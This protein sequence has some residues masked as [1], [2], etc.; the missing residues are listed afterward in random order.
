MIGFLLASALAAQCSGSAC[1][2][3]CTSCAFQPVSGTNLP[4]LLDFVMSSATNSHDAVRT[5]VDRART[6]IA[7]YGGPA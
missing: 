2:S 3:P 4:M 6:A 5:A 7:A 1:P